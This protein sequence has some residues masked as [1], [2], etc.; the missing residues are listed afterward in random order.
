MRKRKASLTYG[1]H[2]VT[3]VQ[4]YQ[5][6]NTTHPVGNCTN[7]NSSLRE[8]L[9]GP[10][11]S[12]CISIEQFTVSFT[13]YVCCKGQRYT[14]QRWIQ[15]C[16][17]DIACI[18]RQWTVSTGVW[19]LSPS[20]VLTSL[21]KTGPRTTNLNAGNSESGRGRAVIKNVFPLAKGYGRAC[22]VQ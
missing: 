2:C 3:F 19:S 15:N 4:T 13:L 20:R 6:R 16:G 18:S 10:P 14:N 17:Q 9:V 21:G 8:A 5:I 12:D 11:I 22:N 7:V 1:R